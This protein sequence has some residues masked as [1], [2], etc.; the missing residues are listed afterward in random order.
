MDI[1]LS[2]DKKVLS[3]VWLLQLYVRQ[4]FKN[5]VMKSWKI[6]KKKTGKMLLFY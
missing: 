6:K 3:V 4:M 2:A 5:C 1:G